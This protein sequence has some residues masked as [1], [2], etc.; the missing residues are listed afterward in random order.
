METTGGSHERQLVASSFLQYN[1]CEHAALLHGMEE[2]MS[3]IQLTVPQDVA[4]SAGLSEHELLVELATS[5]YRERRVSIGQARKLSGLDYTEFFHELGKR[6]IPLD[7]TVED[8]ELDFI[9]AREYIQRK[10]PK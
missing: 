9:T 8:A 7:Y 3:D 1:F 4:A 10:S 2:K 6:Q 5:L